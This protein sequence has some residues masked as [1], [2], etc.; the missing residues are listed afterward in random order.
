MYLKHLPLPVIK[1]FFTLSVAEAN[2][3]QVI[4]TYFPKLYSVKG[5]T[6]TETD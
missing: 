3:E 5:S 6:R 4:L 2:S 1:R